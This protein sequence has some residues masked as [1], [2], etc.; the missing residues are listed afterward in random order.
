[1]RPPDELIDRLPGPLHLLPTDD[2]PR[3]VAYFPEDGT[4]GWYDTEQRARVGPGVEL[5]HEFA[6]MAAGD[7]RVLVAESDDEVDGDSCSRVSIST[8][9]GSS[10][11]RS[12]G[13]D[14]SGAPILPSDPTRSTSAIEALDDDPVYQVQRRDVDTGAVLASAPGFSNVAV[15]GGIVVASTVRR[16]H[17]RARPHVVG[18]DRGAVPGDQRSH[19]EARRRRRSGSD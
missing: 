3:A 18:S 19:A 6:Y 11:R 4:V 9:G 2:P 12:T 1:M 7:D 14:S 10:R 17:P 5:D 16:A 15:G 8:P 13:G